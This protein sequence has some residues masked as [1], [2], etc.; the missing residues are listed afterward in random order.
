MIGCPVCRA[1]GPHFVRTADYLDGHTL[2]ESDETCRRCGYS[3]EFSYGA[4]RETIG[5]V[6]L[7]GSW[8]DDPDADLRRREDRAVALMVR[9]HQLRQFADDEAAWAEQLTRT[10]D[11]PVLLGALADWLEERGRDYD[12]LLF[13]GRAMRAGR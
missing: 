1:T 2:L 12:A 11:D 10:P 13:R 8:S 9:R 3:S 4:T 5:A 7:T 6:E